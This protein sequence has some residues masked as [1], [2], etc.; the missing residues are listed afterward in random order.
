MSVHY[1]NTNKAIYRINELINDIVFHKTF[2]RPLHGMPFTVEMFITG[3]LRC[4]S[5]IIH[6]VI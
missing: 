4:G 5:D 6:G 3:T 1:P 2:L